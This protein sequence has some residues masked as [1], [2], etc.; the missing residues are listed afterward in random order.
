MQKPRR[1]LISV[2]DKTDLNKIARALVNYGVELVSTGGTAAAIKGFGLPCTLVEEITG[3]PEIMDGRVKTLHPKI[4]GALLKVRG[5]P[6]HEAAAE[7]H[8]IGE[9]D[10]VV[11]NLYPFEKTIAKKEVLRREVIEN[12]DI[13]GP[14]MLRS[15]AKNSEWVTVI[16][17]PADYHAVTTSLVLNNGQTTL[18][19]RRKLAAKVFVHTGAY[20][21]MIGSWL[22][23][24]SDF[25]SHLD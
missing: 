15:G 13:G 16:V 1:A 18:S 2:S 10:F 21:T 5:N 8:G 3:F 6:E 25:Q 19:L 12:I 11:V 24:W 20:D 17:D 14:A 23:K 22:S 9:F 4:H 7:K